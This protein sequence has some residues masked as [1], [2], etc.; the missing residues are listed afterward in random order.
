M[1]LGHFLH[2]GWGFESVIERGEW[3]RR[4]VANGRLANGAPGDGSLSVGEPADILV[5]DL[6]ALDRD[7]V[8]SVEPVDLVFARANAAHVARLIVAGEEVVRDGRLTRVDLD[9][10]EA[11]LR[12]DYRRKA[13]SREPF[14]AAWGDLEPAVVAYY[15]D[16]L[17]C[18]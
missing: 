16:E 11:A 18:C 7:A 4:I 2:G 12:A 14:V 1:R 9:G 17:G 13:Q 8:M 15:R 10:T 6:D 5:L 3:L